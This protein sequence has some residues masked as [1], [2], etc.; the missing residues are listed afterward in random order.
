MSISQPN[1]AQA[2]RSLAQRFLAEPLLHFAIVAVCLFGLQ[3][4][5]QDDEREV[6][7]VDGSAQ[8]FLIEQR[9]DLLQRP[10]SDAEKQEVVAAYVDDE[11]LV[12]EARNRGFADGGRIRKLLLQNMRFFIAGDIPQASEQELRAFFENNPEEFTTPES[13]DLEQRMFQDLS[14]VPADYLNDLRSG[15]ATGARDA[16]ISLNYPKDI[17]GVNM[18]RLAQAFGSENAIE[19]WAL[20]DGVWSGP[21]TSPQDSVHFIRVVARH[22]AQ[23]LEYEDVQDWLQTQ[24]GSVQSKKLIEAELARLRPSYRIEILNDDVADK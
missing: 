24:W 17:R 22:P 21:L 13:I 23:T 5:V 2:D 7:V 11:I 4:V 14:Q 20:R 12:R 1:N 15:P 10:L 19:I 9:E 16:T 6:I 18:P 8:E 3:A